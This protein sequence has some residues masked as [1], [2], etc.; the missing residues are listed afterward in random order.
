MG[1]SSYAS[2]GTASGTLY[3]GSG[4]TPGGTSLA[5]YVAGIGIGGTNGVNNL[6][7][8]A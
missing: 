1:G 4:S 3:P 2:N 7:G 8:H 5:G 6:F